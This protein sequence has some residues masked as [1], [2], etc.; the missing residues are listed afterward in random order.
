MLSFESLFNISLCCIKWHVRHIVW[1][2]GEPGAARAVEGAG[3]GEGV[4][5]LGGQGWLEG[6]R[7]AAGSWGPLQRSGGRAWW[8]VRSFEVWRV[9][10]ARGGSVAQLLASNHASPSPDN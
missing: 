4:K 2:P 7:D 1:S 8:G 10:Q 9:F 6:Q 5:L 3:A